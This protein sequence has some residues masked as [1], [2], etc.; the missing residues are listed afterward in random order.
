M[1]HILENIEKI[2]GT[3]AEES[4]FFLIDLSIRGDKNKR[5]FEI[6]IDGEQNISAEDL[7]EVS[8]KIQALM[9]EDKSFDFSYR[10][11][12]SSP[13]TDRPLKFLKQFPK[14]INRKFEIDYKAG[15]EV[16]KIKGKLLKVEPESL[17]FLADNKEEL[18]LNFND[19]I[20]AKVIVS[21]S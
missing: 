10:L 15:D 5:I 11:D 8:R 3:A 2:A 7:A 12:V 13:G 1:S 21:F 20:K 19:I 4:G 18:Q 6:Y 16:K 17:V 9:E 14:H